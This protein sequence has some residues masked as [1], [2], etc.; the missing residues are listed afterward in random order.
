ML[1][2]IY[3]PTEG[4]ILFRG[5]SLVGK[6]THD[7]TIRGIARTFQNIRLFKNLSALDNIKI[8]RH[9]R[10]TYG[11]VPA[12]LRSRSVAE[13]ERQVEEECL[14]LLEKNSTCF[15][16][17]T[18]WPRTALRHPAAARNRPCPGHFAEAPLSGRAAAGMN[19]QEWTPWRIPLTWIR[20]EFPGDDPPHRASHAARHGDLQP[21]FRPELGVTIAE[22]QPEDIKNDPKVI[23]AYLGKGGRWHDARREGPRVAYGAIEA[24]KASPS[25]WKRGRSSRSW[26]PTARARRASSGP[27]QVLVPA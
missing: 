15:P 23:E 19:P 22:G 7:Y 2:G 12:F 26:A 11:L 1:T 24:V 10:I 17:P 3:A 16:S 5:E 25:P 4:E 6:P 18:R 20:K 8:A 14:V 13:T 21:H 9:P 27:S